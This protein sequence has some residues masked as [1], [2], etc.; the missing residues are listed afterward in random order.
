ME[1]TK[2]IKEG[3]FAVCVNSFSKIK[4]LSAL[5]LAA[6]TM[7]L[8]PLPSMAA[9]GALG[10]VLT[11]IGGL[12]ITV[13]AIVGVVFVVRYSIDVAKDGKGSVGK[14]VTSVLVT[15][16]LIGLIVTLMNV[17]ALQGIF[18]GVAN[19]AVETTGNVANEALS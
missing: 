15:L 16:L 8:M 17:E 12:C 1:F 4:T 6:M 5:A 9:S 18:G 11:S 19:K 10:G 13:V 2:G 14:I 7:M 3:I